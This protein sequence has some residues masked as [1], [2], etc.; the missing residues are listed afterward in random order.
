MSHVTHMNESCHTRE[1]FPHKQTQIRTMLNE[2]RHAYSLVMSHI[3]MND[4]RVMSNTGANT[5]QVDT[6]S[7][8]M[9]QT[10][11]NHVTHT[12]ESYV[13]HDSSVFVT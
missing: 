2:S 7:H 10:L 8:V 1:V 11:M 5:A 12:D 3:S 4:A 9:S 6:R 13:S